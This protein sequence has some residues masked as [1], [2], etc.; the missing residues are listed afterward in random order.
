MQARGTRKTG[1]TLLVHVPLQHYDDSTVRKG[2]V[3][4]L[5]PRRKKNY[6]LVAICNVLRIAPLCLYVKSVQTFGLPRDS[7]K[8]YSNTQSVSASLCRLP[9]AA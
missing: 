5:Q 3:Q 2:D 1:T 7:P 8:W 9:C 4:Y 6:P